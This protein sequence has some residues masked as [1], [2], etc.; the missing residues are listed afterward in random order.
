MKN[1]ARDRTFIEN[2]FELEVFEINRH[3]S[4]LGIYCILKQMT[5]FH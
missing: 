5:S 4:G 1:L 2:T 3:C